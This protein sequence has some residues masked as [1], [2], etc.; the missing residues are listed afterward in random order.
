MIFSDFLL[1]FLHHAFRSHFESLQIR[2][3]GHWLLRYPI[4]CTTKIPM[5]TM[6]DTA[7]NNN[8]NMK[9]WSFIII[10]LLCKNYIMSAQHYGVD[11]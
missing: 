6:L 7:I 9:G 8:I 2:V 11:M 4:H 5:E 10:F 1:Y 3:C